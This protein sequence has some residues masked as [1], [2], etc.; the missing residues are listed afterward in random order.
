VVAVLQEIEQEK[1]VSF[2]VFFTG[3]SLGGWLAQI[4]TFTTEYLELKG[5][6]F[7]YHHC[8]LY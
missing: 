4:T 1:K 2:E 8:N 3:H 5:G 7:L 6:T